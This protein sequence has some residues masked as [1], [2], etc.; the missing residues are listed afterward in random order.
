MRRK[1]D[2]AS[3]HSPNR[4]QHGN[5]I[6][7]L[8]E[9]RRDGRANGR[10]LASPTHTRRNYSPDTPLRRARANSNTRLCMSAGLTPGILAA[11]ANV[12]GRRAASF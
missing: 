7:P 12:S 2:T 3:H 8:G 1:R 10:R 11:W 9:R 5:V 6:R 4:T